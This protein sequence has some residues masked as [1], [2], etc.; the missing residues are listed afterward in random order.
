MSE[1]NPKKSIKVDLIIIATAIIFVVGLSIW[2]ILS[3]PKLFESD[4]IST[5]KVVDKPV[6]AKEMI[7]P[8]KSYLLPRDA[9]ALSRHVNYQLLGW[10]FRN[11]KLLFEEPSMEIEI[12]VPAGTKITHENS[13]EFPEYFVW[14]T[15][16]IKIGPRQYKARELAVVGTDV[17]KLV[18]PGEGDHFKFNASSPNELIP[19]FIQMS[20]RENFNWGSVQSGLWMLSQ[21]ISSEDFHKI[22]VHTYHQLNPM[23]GTD[24]IVAS[25]KGLKFTA[26]VFQDLGLNPMDYQLLADS[27]NKF[28]ELLKKVDFDAPSKNYSSIIVNKSLLAYQIEPEVEKILIRYLTEHPTPHIRLDALR[29]LTS[30]EVV[31]DAEIIFHKLKNE[32]HR[33][34]QFLYAYRLYKIDDTRGFPLLA[35]FE[36]DAELNKYFTDYL[37]SKIK[38]LSGI[39]RGRNENLFTYWERALGWGSLSKEGLNSDGLRPLTEKIMSAPDPILVKALQQAQ[40]PEQGEVNKAIRQL[41][42]YRNSPEAFAMLV[43]LATKHEDGNV[44]FSAMNSLT[45]FREFKLKKICEDRILNDPDYRLAQVALNIAGS[46]KFPGFENLFLLACKHEH[47]SVRLWAVRG[48]GNHKISQGESILLELAKNDS[49]RNIRHGAISSLAYGLKTYALFPLLKEML[50][51]TD[52]AD[53]WNAL[54]SLK[55]WKS[56]PDALDMLEPYRNDPLIGSRVIPHLE[57]YGR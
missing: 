54:N 53:K 34:V 6:P 37:P 13:S 19:R 40:S 4:G 25:Y 48:I 27:R 36:N 47:K 14:K 32:T 7:K 12:T 52:E 26:N 49:E 16:N 33:H 1:G 8:V 46:Q 11:L 39:E 35:A 5:Q 24:S 15:A 44:R 43:E 18:E 2:F 29:N 31:D 45:G 51:S 17:N 21:N 50:Q 30:M 22:R 38:K 23:G 3:I 57:K 55:V 56:N 10:D 9:E 28:L 41:K 20:E 42:I